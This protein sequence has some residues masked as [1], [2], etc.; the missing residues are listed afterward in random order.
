MQNNLEHESSLGETALARKE[1]E[2]AGSS[3][4]SSGNCSDMELSEREGGP[5]VKRMRSNSGG[6][7]V[8]ANVSQDR[9]MELSECLPGRVGKTAEEEDAREKRMVAAVRTLLTEMGED[10]ER[11]GLMK[12]PLR[13]TKALLYFTQGY[14][15]NLHELV[16]E[17]IFDENHHEM[18]IV[19][20]IDLFSMCEHHLVPFH[21]KCHIGYIPKCRILGISKLARVSEMFSRRLQVQERL[22]TQIAEAIMEILDPQG[23]GVVIEAAHMCMVGRG[24]QKTGAKTVTSS[25]RGVFQ[26]DS[27]TRQEFFAHLHNR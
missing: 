22:T 4:Q 24:V 25:V 12:T 14:A 6:S 18:I 26:S 19:K 13:M 11:E 1:E 23:V 16:N 17:A 5:V 21:G 8:A 3:N 9:L 15:Q 2:A 7:V 10:P 20:D 27:R